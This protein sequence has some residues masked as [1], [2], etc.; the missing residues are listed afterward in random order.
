MK[1]CIIIPDSYK[2]TLSA[3]E[4]C[5][6]GKEVILCH[7]PTCE[8]VCIPVADGGEGT[9]DCF[10]EALG[11]QR[12]SVLSTGP[13]GE[14]V[15]AQYARFNGTAFVEMAQNAGLPMVGEH[16]DPGQTTTY[17][18]GEVIH[19]AVEAGCKRIVLGL[20]G[21][22]T[23]DAGTGAACALGTKFYGTDGKAFLPKG[24]TLERI[25][26]Y[27]TSVTQKLLADCHITAMCDIDNVMYGPQ[28]AAEVFASQKGADRWQV[29][30]LDAGLCALGSLI[31][32]QSGYDIAHRPG[33]GAAGAFGAG[34]AA[35]LGGEL[36]P[37]I[38]TVLDC[39]G[40]D[41]LLEGTDMIFTG[42]GCIDSQSLRGKAVIGIARRAKTH[43][44]PVTVV[45]GSVG[46]GAES[47]YELGVSA[48]FSINRR[49]EDFSVSQ[50]KTKKNFSASMDAIV[51]LIA[52][53]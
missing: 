28:G 5:R 39:V 6:L 21:S 1:K 34:V 10:V 18:V 4:F 36:R 15:V 52:A 37:G 41:D 13:W 42:E 45:A 44:V 12:V 47:A 20:G 43:G 9:V 2:G 35:F 49:A 46:E 25:T 3:L 22:C 30:R 26:S 50:F 29:K 16:K 53:R 19:A 23:N 48:I 24:N 14:R 7:F 8:V 31:E 38:E 17:G 40:F 33:A 32:A 27:D 51:R 11:A